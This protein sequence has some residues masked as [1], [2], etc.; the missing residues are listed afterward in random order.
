[1]YIAYIFSFKKITRAMQ[2]AKT[3]RDSLPWLINI[4]LHATRVH[5]HADIKSSWSSLNNLID[6]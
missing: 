1:M 5:Q 4:S 2:A 6:V 3:Q